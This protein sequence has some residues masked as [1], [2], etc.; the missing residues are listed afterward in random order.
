MPTLSQSLQGS[1]LGHLRIVAELWGIEP[2]SGEPREALKTLCTALL[3]RPFVEEAYGALP[4]EA[5]M[6][7][8]DLAHNQG[9]LPWQLFTRRYGTVREMGPAR[10]DREQPHRNPVSPA[11]MLWYRALVGRGFFDSPSGPAEFAYIPDDLAELLPVEPARPPASFGCPATPSERA[12]WLPATD[13][14][15]D[16]ACTLL[17]ALRMGKPVDALGASW[18]VSPYPLAPAPLQVLLSAAGLLDSNGLPH[19]EAARLFLEAGRG[20]ALAQLAQ[21]WL[22]SPAVNDL[23]LVPHLEAEGDWVNDPLLARRAVLEFLATIPDD[24]WWSLQAFVTGVHQERPDFQRPVGDYDSWFIRDRRTGEFLRG[25]ER[26]DE[27]DGALLRYL[28]CGPLHWL[29]ILDLALPAPPD[30]STPR[31]VVTAFRYSAWGKALLIG[32][33]PVGL[34][35]EDAPL[36]LSSSARLRVPRLA[37]RA[38]RYQIARFCAWEGERDGD[39]LYRLT[40]ASLRNARQAG[41]T[42]NHLVG[43][44]RRS[45]RTVPPSLARA[46]ERWEGHGSEARLE[47]VQVLR[48]ATPE[49]LQQLRK[50]R[51]ARFL[52]DPLGPTTVVV[53]RGAGE[54][55]LAIL[56]EMGFLGE[57]VEE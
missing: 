5:R 36:L 33:A 54:K 57:V 13:R 7:V 35:A 15:L 37:P 45:A 23:R 19:P 6:A 53:R 56:A 17:A 48:L 29:G 30:T 40:P 50:S 25:F 28:I 20:Q 21:A 1:D 42:I 2:Q 49:M 3:D 18:N 47:N 41:L 26:W 43:L 12:Y 16:H 24:T 8:E 4:E 31:L 27:V 52:G 55:V 51:A 46:L 14:V 10:R 11:E 22:D 32:M 44:L 9:R 38:A 39:Y 34:D